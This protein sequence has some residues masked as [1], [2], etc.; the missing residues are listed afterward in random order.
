MRV[1]RPSASLSTAPRPAELDPGLTAIALVSSIPYR[2]HARV[3]GYVAAAHRG[4]CCRVWYAR[5]NGVPR[6]DQ[7]A[8]GA[9][10]R[11]LSW[12]TPSCTALHGGMRRCGGASLLLSQRTAFGQHLLHCLPAL[13]ATRLAPLIATLCERLLSL[14]TGES[15][16]SGAAGAL[17]LSDKPYQAFSIWVPVEL[18]IAAA[19]VRSNRT[20]MPPF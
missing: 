19:P 1:L 18:V 6:G 3:C 5:T 13:Q 11:G 2:L 7:P 9:M 4:V 14:A 20:R 10:C 12:R 8:R 17:G 16:S 15:R